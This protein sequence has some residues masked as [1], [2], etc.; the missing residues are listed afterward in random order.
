[1]SERLRG[2]LCDLGIAVRARVLD[3]RDRP[4]RA[5]VA[6][7]TEADVIY[8]IDRV[9]ESTAVDWLERH[10]PDDEPIR[11]VM[12]GL[13]APRTFGA[14]STKW[15]CI[16]DPIDGT[17]C[18][19]TDKRSAWVLAGIAPAGGGVGEIEVCAMTELPPTRQWRGDQASA[20]RGQGVV[21]ES[22]DLRADTRR[23]LSLHP[24]RATDFKHGFASLAKF[25]PEGKARIAAVEERLWRELYGDSRVPLVFDDQY[26]STGGQVY[27]ILAGRD[28]MVGDIR[29]YVLTHS[30]A[31][32]PY[33]ICTGMLIQE[34]GGVLESPTGE[35]LAGPLDTTSAIA[36]VG[37][38]N[39]TLADLVRPILARL[40][41][42]LR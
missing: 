26:V 27:E 9:A 6:G 15:T 36:W 2:L 18:L 16:V 25:F 5:D 21:A 33:D 29:P 28:R 10:W 13:D 32:H 7:E 14:G 41:G 8:G 39:P 4:D 3:A 38:A 24:S 31:C 12:E 1:M 34:A 20:V 37:Y 23:P 19:M 42:E 22:F 30:L 35:P 40:V 17:R 11:L